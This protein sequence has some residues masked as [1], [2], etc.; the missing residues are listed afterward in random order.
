LGLL[1]AAAC[2]G[3]AATQ[4]SEGNHSDTTILNPLTIDRILA[5]ISQAGLAVP[6]PRDVTQ[7]DC[8]R[9]GCTNKVETD[10]FSVIM[11][12]TPGRAQL[13]AGSIQ[14]VF[15]IEDVVMTFTSGVPTDQ[16]LAYERA[17]THTVQ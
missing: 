8:P 17:V 6:N 11:F 14:H 15:Q 9:I 4:T 1:A 13:Y 3:H 10:T 7:R 2:G 5:S 16:Q 12:P